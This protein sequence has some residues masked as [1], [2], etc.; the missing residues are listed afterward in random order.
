MVASFTTLFSP[1]FFFTYLEYNI[2]FSENQIAITFFKV[3]CATYFTR[4]KD[5]FF[6]RLI[7]QERYVK[8]EISR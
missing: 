4:K 5:N 1:P 2:T 6:P 8:E 3:P 7:R